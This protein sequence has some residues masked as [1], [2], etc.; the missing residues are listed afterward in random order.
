MPFARFRNAAIAVVLL[1]LVGTSVYSLVK[2]SSVQASLS[3]AQQQISSEKSKLSA[4]Q[5][6]VSS[7]EQQISTLQSTVDSQLVNTLSSLGKYDSVCSMSNVPFSGQ[8]ETAYMPCTDQ[9]PS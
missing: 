5:Q 8:L 6:Q 1:I 2:L 9:N 7:D 3:H 4:E